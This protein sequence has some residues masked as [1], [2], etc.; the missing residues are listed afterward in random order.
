ME[1]KPGPE[2]DGYALYDPKA[3]KGGSAGAG[4]PGGG[5]DGAAKGRGPM[6]DAI[7]FMIGGGNY[8]EYHGLLEMAS[9]NPAAPKSIVYGTTECNPKT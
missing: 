6:K 7:V 3:A 4:G 1:G 9:R 2:T 8:L 5:A